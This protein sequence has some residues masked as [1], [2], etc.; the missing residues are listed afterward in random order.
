MTCFLPV[1]VRGRVAKGYGE[2]VRC[3]QV[4]IDGSEVS[5]HVEIV[6]VPSK[7]QGASA[8]PAAQYRYSSRRN[9]SCY[10]YFINGIEFT[11][12]E[13]VDDYKSVLGCRRQLIKPSELAVGP[14]K[15]AD[16]LWQEVARARGPVVCNTRGRNSWAEPYRSQWRVQ[17]VRWVLAVPLMVDGQ[18]AGS[19]RVCSRQ[20]EGYRA[21]QI[22]LA[23]ALAQQAAVCVQLSR[24]AGQG[25]QWAVVE[26]R[27][28]LARDIHD[29]LAPSLTAVVLHLD[30]AHAALEVG[31][32]DEAVRHIRRAG[33]QARLGLN[34]A[35]RSVSGLR[36]H[37]AEA[38]NLG[39]AFRTL[40]EET[41]SGTEVCASFRLQGV[42]RSL[43]PDWEEHL[44]RI[45]QEALTNTLKHT[46]ARRFEA[47]LAFEPHELRLELCDDGSG[48][49]PRTRKSGFGLTGMNERAT[50]MG[51]RL[52]LRTGA[53]QGTAI[54]LSLPY[55][56]AP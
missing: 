31:G 4:P 49:D 54:I 8:L 46:H 36:A 18:V 21:E 14:L 50:T 6:S 43:P 12:I 32:T 47:R 7:K 5:C 33:E 2:T 44:L 48:F 34:E 27:N 53:G 52:T 39:K 9:C 56:P 10:R 19:I 13:F 30:A 22:E 35:R 26:E 16:P 29:S 23:Q 37:A 24:L 51:G 15:I 42:P 1:P 25:C 28:R 41:A 17:G 40:L 45:G 55:S 20:P 11:G 38:G 3:Y